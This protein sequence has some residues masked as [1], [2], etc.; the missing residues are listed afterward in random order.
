MISKF[1]DA[2]PR[3]TLPWLV[4]TIVESYILAQGTTP[5]DLPLPEISVPLP[6]IRDS[7]IPTPPPCD[8]SFISSAFVKP[9][10]LTESGVSTPKHEIGKPRSV[11]ILDKT[12]D[13]KPNHPFHNN[14]KNLFSSS[15]FLSL[16]ATA[17]T[18]LL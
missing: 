6:L 18:T 1:T 17:L 3:L 9:I 15:G 2:A 8:V 13:A 11:P 10:P 12:G 5:S 16:I 4:A 7:E 14:L